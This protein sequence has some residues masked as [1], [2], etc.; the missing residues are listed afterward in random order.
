MKE[1]TDD[2]NK[3]KA[4]TKRKELKIAIY[5]AK[6]R[7]LNA[8]AE[9]IESKQTSPGDIWK[10]LNEANAGEFGHQ[11][12]AITIKMK[13]SDGTFAK[14]DIENAKVF[15]QHNTKLNKAI[16][17]HIRHQLRQSNHRRNR[18][19]PTRKQRTWNNTNKKRS[20][21]CVQENGIRKKPRLKWHYY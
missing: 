4:K 10:A 21:N 8:K 14:I 11:I 6:E 7:W 18:R 9:E 19:Q 20:R 15:Q 1:K 12:K 5:E 3:E 16:Q 2:N 13:K 17:Q